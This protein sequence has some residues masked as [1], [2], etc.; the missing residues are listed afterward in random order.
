MKWKKNG[1]CQWTFHYRWHEYYYRWFPSTQKYLG[2][3]VDNKL[4]WNNHISSIKNDIEID[5]ILYKCHRYFNNES[6]ISL[7]HTL[8]HPYFSYCIHHDAV[9]KW[10]HFPRYWPF[11][12]GIHRWP[13][14]SPHKGQWRG[15][16]MLSLICTWTYVWVNNKDAGDLRRH[17]VHYD[18]TVVMFRKI[19]CQQPEATNN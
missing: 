7:Y 11:V 14:N 17:R 19:I 5:R 4:T 3:F 13:V 6:L 18:V 10:K 8:V 16:V 2:V 12:Q 1:I 15:A 9:I